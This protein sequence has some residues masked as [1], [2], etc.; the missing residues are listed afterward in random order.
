M[1]PMVEYLDKRMAKEGL[2]K[3]LKKRR[4]NGVLIYGFMNRMA[5]YGFEITPYYWE[6]EAVK[7]C[8]APNIKGDPLEY[9]TAF[10]GEAEIR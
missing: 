10:I 3:D 5:R 8:E 6:K 9:S 2:L 1:A 4:K 7:K